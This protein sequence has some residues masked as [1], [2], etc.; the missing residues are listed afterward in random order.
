M[1]PSFPPAICDGVIHPCFIVRKKLLWKSQPRQAVLLLYCYRYKIRKYYFS[2]GT[3]AG[4]S[5]KPSFVTQSKN[6]NTTLLF[7]LRTLKDRQQKKT[8]QWIPL[9]PWATW[10]LC[11]QPLLADGISEEPMFLLK[12]ACAWIFCKIWKMSGLEMH[13][14]NL[15]CSRVAQLWSCSN[16]AVL[17]EM[18]CR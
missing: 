2:S 9:V 3:S 6:P 1:I 8:K 17:A 12:T 11:T 7:I 10:Q 4:N 14:P 13:P 18:S 15:L 16:Y 5:R